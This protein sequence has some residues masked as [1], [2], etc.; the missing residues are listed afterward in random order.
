M[1]YRPFP[2]V[3]RALA[4]VRR[5]QPDASV[6]SMSECLRPMADRFAALRENTRRAAEQ[7]FGMTV[8]EYRISSRPQIVGGGS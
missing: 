5:H 2:N 4:Q 6:I 3:D 7:G 8:D 1:A